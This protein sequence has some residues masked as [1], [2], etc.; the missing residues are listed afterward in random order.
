ME[1]LDPFPLFPIFWCEPGV[2]ELDGLGSSRACRRCP[3]WSLSLSRPVLGGVSGP[4]KALRPCDAPSP[5][6]L[7]NKFVGWDRLRCS[8]QRSDASSTPP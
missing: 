5:V 4:E 7:A 3:S 8:S 2:A 1:R 6:A